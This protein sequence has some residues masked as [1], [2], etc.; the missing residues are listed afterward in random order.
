VRSTDQAN[1]TDSTP[2]SFTWIIDTLRPTVTI[3]QAAGQADPT[4]S[5][6]INFTV[7]FNEPV[8]GFTSSDV[9]LGGTAGATTALVTGSGTTYNIAVSGITSTGTI[10]V[11]IPANVANDAAG[12][13]NTVSTSTDNSVTA[14]SIPKW[15]AYMPLIKAP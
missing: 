9:T 10:T 4:D 15:R 2:A 8:T 12:N 13:G 11:S 1:K 3:D 14:S 7:I 6:P 5:V